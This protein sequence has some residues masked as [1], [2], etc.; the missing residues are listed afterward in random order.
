MQYYNHALRYAQNH[1]LRVIYMVL[2]ALVWQA[3]FFSYE[4][5]R[6]VSHL[7]IAYTG[8]ENFISPFGLVGRLG[9]NKR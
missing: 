8:P 6:Y 7:C 2:L 9:R 4:R 5:L 3:L 1:N